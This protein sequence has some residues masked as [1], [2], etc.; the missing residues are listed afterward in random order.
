MNFVS[1]WKLVYQNKNESLGTS[2][3]DHDDRFQ[4]WKNSLPIKI[5]SLF[6]LTA[7]PHQ[8]FGNRSH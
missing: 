7:Q 4:V 5:L 2:M 6:A 8:H 1:F 3:T